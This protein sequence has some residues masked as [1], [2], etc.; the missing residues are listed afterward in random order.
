MIGVMDRRPGQLTWS[1]LRPPLLGA[2]LVTDLFVVLAL[3]LARPDGWVPPLI[4]FGI[5]LAG[6]V[7]TLAWAIRHRGDG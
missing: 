4:A 3:A 6:L 1:R 2:L 5:V 7:L